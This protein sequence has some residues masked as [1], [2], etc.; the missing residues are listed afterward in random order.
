[1]FL[2]PIYHCSNRAPE[3]CA[4]ADEG[5]DL[6]DALH[7]RR[8]L[9]CVCPAPALDLALYSRLASFCIK[10][11]ILHRLACFRDDVVFCIF[12]YQRSVPGPCPEP[13]PL[14]RTLH[15]WIYRI[16]PKRVNEY[17]QVMA[18][19]VDAASVKEQKDPKDKVKLAT[20][21]KEKVE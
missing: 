18:S 6:Q 5:D 14:T 17:G 19:D 16:D 2:S 21:A 13:P 8:R 11:P 10:M 1:M 4:H 7:R 12:L 20:K 9:L 15:R 3:C